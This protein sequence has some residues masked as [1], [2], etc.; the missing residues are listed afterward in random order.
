LN[1]IVLYFASGESLYSGALLLLVVIL[2][3]PFL[4]QKW[5]GPL[6]NIFGWLALLL[7]VM[8]SPPFPWIVDA[9]FLITFAIWYLVWNREPRKRHPRFLSAATLAFF[10][11]V[12]PAVERLHRAFPILA[13]APSDHLVVIGDS[14]SAGLGSQSPWPT[15][16][17]QITNIPARNISRAGATTAEA[18]QLAALVTPQD[19]LVLIEIGGNDLIANF[20]S[21]S[22]EASL[23]TVIS[24]LAAPGRTLVMFEL[25]L[26]PHKVEY[27]QIQ[28]R[29]AAKYG[30]WLIPKRYF[31]YIITG[32]DA[33]SDGLHLTPTGADRMARLVARVFLPILTAP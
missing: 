19:K 16:F 32:A 9:A 13:G 5:T 31:V 21:K 2:V 22:F 6:R 18:I 27:G 17:Q 28:R 33:T 25:P 26:L 3:S 30:V 8:S 14:I 20:A 29:L 12:L 15:L 24:S 1:P 7:I 23:Q 4:R 10:V 11:F